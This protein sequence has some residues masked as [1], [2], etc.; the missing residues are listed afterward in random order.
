MSLLS[1]TLFNHPLTIFLWKSSKIFTLAD[2]QPLSIFCPVIKSLIHLSVGF[3][4]TYYKLILKRLLILLT[5][6]LLFVFLVN[7]GLVNLSCLGLGLIFV[8][9]TNGLRCLVLNPNYS[10]LDLVSLKAVTCP[11]LCF[12]YL[13]TVFIDF[14]TIVTFYVLLKTSNYIR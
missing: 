7:L 13:S 12:L 3:R 4:L 5:I 9:D 10:C 14:C 6:I 2:Q 8:T 11:H 1:Q